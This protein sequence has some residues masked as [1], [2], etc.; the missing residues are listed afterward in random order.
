MRCHKLLVRSS[1]LVASWSTLAVACAAD[2]G[3]PP[4]VSGGQATVTFT[5]RPPSAEAFLFIADDGPES[6]ALREQ[7]ADSFDSFD[8]RDVNAHG[9][10]EPLFDPAAWHP[11]D[12]TVIVARPSITGL[13]HYVTPLD[14]PRLHWQSHQHTKEDAAVLA[15][16][17][18]EALT[19]STATTGSAAP[20]LASLSQ[21]WT[22]LTEK[23]MALGA[24]D[25][26]LARSL[27]PNTFT[28]IVL[29]S[30]RD[31]DSTGPPSA[32]AIDD[33]YPTATLDLA[34]VI[35]PSRTL[36][37]GRACDTPS[38][39]PEPRFAE[40]LR[41]SDLRAVQWW[42][43]D[44]P[45]VLDLPYTDC[46]TTC[47]SW[48]PMKGDAGQAVCRIHV[49][50]ENLDACPADLGWLDPLGDDGKRRPTITTTDGHDS[51]TCEIRQLEG[52]GL[53]ACRHT[54]E[55]SGCDPGWCFTEV[56]EL[57]RNDCTRSW[58]YPAFRFVGGSAVAMRAK[59]T[60]VCDVARL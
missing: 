57:T 33:P 45:H 6:A 58:I 50:A 38:G 53:E 4:S 9:S 48:R 44:K 52:T 40:W 22:L 30:A 11:V 35:A 28:S 25:D 29:A 51:R 26:K 49:Q 1:L 3:D 37:P 24:E 34:S 60:L 8:E 2:L 41:A 32:Y 59:A 15:G 10:C 23:R 18:R 16:A 42:P 55:C 5:V 17:A 46:R 19:N 27:A 54:L 36:E 7:I 56:P 20:I 39:D 43:C 21:A 14:D 12:R 31:D 13:A 47:L